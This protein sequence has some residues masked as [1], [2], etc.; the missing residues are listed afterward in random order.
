[1]VVIMDFL[2][3]LVIKVIAAVIYDCIQN[4]IYEI[5]SSVLCYLYYTIKLC[6]ESNS[7]WCKIFH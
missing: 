7:N 3:L 1:M 5:G 6:D 2:L 4:V